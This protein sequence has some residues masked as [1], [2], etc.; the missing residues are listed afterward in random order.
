MHLAKDNRTLW[1]TVRSG[2]TPGLFVSRHTIPEI[3]I[4][5]VTV[6]GWGQSYRQE[7]NKYDCASFVKMGLQN[8]TVLGNSVPSV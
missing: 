1:N 5:V 6:R 8:W 2:R 4:T 7:A 3:V